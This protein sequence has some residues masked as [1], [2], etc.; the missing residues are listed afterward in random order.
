MRCSNKEL[1]YVF[2]Y[3]F[4]GYLRKSHVITCS[5]SETNRYYYRCASLLCLVAIATVCSHHLTNI[6]VEQSL[7][8]VAASGTWS[9]RPEL[10]GTCAICSCLPVV[11]AAVIFRLSSRC[12]LAK[13]FAVFDVHVRKS[14]S[15]AIHCTH[16]SL[17]LPHRKD[18][19]RW[20]KKVCRH[21]RCVD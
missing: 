18:S 14:Q 20:Q 10:Y 15:T 3:S 21:Q 4:V 12:L 5:A 19:E 7:H 2:T 13:G 11:F 9:L 17:R 8:P 16:C 1:Q 6:P